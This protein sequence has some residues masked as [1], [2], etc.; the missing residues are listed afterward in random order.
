MVEKQKI[1]FS[2]AIR[3]GRER[4]EVYRHII[5]KI[6]ENGEVL[7]EHI[8]SKD[9]EKIEKETNDIS[10]Y[11]KDIMLLNEADA[12]IAEVTVPSLG[13]GY[14]IAY[15]EQHGKPVLCLYD[16][17]DK[18]H[19]LSAMISGNRNIILAIYDAIEKADKAIAEFMK[20]N[21]K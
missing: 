4:V 10:I 19:K 14:E 5:E 8:G 21:E 3:G 20:N 13:V 17:T 6:K 15:A 1:Y 12:V 18:N 9:L 2:G 11:K 16:S 7:T